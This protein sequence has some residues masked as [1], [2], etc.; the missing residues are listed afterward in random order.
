MPATKNLERM[1]HY[2]CSETCG[3]RSSTPPRWERCHSCGGQ[4]ETFGEFCGCGAQ[5]FSH[6]CPNCDADVVVNHPDTVRP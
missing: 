2:E 3:F 4:S 6:I 5:D 1:Q